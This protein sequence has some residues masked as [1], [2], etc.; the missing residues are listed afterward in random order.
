MFYRYEGVEEEVIMEI[1]VNNKMIGFQLNIYYKFIPI[2]I[3][4]L[5]RHG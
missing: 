2:N 4:M 3:I 5:S 1:G